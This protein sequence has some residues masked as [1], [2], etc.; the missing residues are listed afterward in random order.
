[1]KRFDDMLPEELEEQHNELITML[2]QASQQAL[3]RNENGEKQ[4]I[5]RVGEKLAMLEGSAS[6]EGR[7]GQFKEQQTLS[8]R[9]SIFQRRLSSR[10]QYI[11]TLAALLIVGLLIGASIALFNSRSASMA[12][13]PVAAP[14]TVSTTVNG[15]EMSMSVTSGPYFLSELVF[16]N[17]SLTNH[18]H[19]AFLLQGLPFTTPCEPALRLHQTA[20]ESPHYTLPL[21]SFF[22]NCLKETP[23]ELKPGQTITIQQYEPLTSTGHVTLS[24]QATFLKPGGGIMTSPLDGHWPSLQIQVA[25]KIPSDRLL[26]LHLNGSQLLINAPS[27]VHPVYQFSEMCDG[28][29]VASGTPSWMS[30]STHMLN[31]SDNTAGCPEKHAHWQYVVSAAGYAIIEQKYPVQ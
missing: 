18:T 30:I 24:A 1:M 11:N 28:L 5:Q 7:S 31:L 25:S 3:M 13:N 8:R 16:A 10:K 23:N 26:S 6:Q 21:A 17:M 9:P 15:L 19:T 20:G 2:M 14:T 12:I 4:A 22:Y 29:S 27:A